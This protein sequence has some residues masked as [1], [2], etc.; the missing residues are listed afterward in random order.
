MAKVNCK[1]IRERA[2]RINTA[3]K[4]HAPTA[5]FNNIEQADYEASINAAAAKDQQIADAEANL[6]I[7]KDERDDLYRNINNDS[8]KVRDGVEGD[9]NYG[10][11]SPLVGAMG[12]VRKSERSSGL[13]HKT[14]GENEGGSQ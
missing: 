12:F 13:T 10:T 3:W 14:Q 4:Q 6:R 7:L 5:K 2:N 9:S 8:V 1:E 11:D